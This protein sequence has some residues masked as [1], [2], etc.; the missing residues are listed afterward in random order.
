MYFQILLIYLKSKF[1]TLITMFFF[2]SRLKRNFHSY[3]LSICFSR[4]ISCLI[5][6]TRIIGW[7]SWNSSNITAT[8]FHLK[9][10]H[11][12][13]KWFAYTLISLAPISTSLND[14][15]KIILKSIYI[16]IKWYQTF[17]KLSKYEIKCNVFSNLHFFCKSPLAS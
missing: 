7:S 5:Y 15:G 1:W 14:D 17:S 10:L 6:H 11:R 13:H 4:H 9:I 12:Q 3:K 2:L 8:K 16:F